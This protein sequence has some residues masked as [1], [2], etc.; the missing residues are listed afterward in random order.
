MF[1]VHLVQE[2]L[3]GRAVGV[4][5]RGDGLEV[6]DLPANSTLSIGFGPRGRKEEQMTGGVLLGMENDTGDDDL[7]NDVGQSCDR[8][9]IRVPAF[10]FGLDMFKGNL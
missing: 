2:W 7:Y 6:L 8:L 4:N 5:D 3:F 1:P 10:T 9:P